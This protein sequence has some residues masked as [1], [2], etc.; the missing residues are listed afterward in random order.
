M[1][2]GK[3]HG[4]SEG[5]EQDEF[6]RIVGRLPSGNT[7]NVPI[8]FVKNT[9]EAEI[10]IGPGS[11]IALQNKKGRRS[12]S[13]T[14]GCILTDYR[15]PNENKYALTCGHIFTN[16]ASEGPRGIL[17]KEERFPVITL[18][19]GKVVGDWWEGYINGVLDVALVKLHNDIV[20]PGNGVGFTGAQK[21]RKQKNL[22]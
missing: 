19:N 11:A 15:H 1:G 7:I 14:F 10:V 3:H 4:L 2:S 6:H 22:S 12:S 18:D 17:S 21:R 13:G 16:G 9:G 20:A 8:V 5:R